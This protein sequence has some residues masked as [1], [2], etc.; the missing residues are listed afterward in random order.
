MGKFSER[1]YTNVS[2]IWLHITIT[3][4]P[5]KNINVQASPQI[6]QIKMFG[7]GPRQ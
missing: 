1:E 7:V 3:W 4:G 5:L 6:N 2:K